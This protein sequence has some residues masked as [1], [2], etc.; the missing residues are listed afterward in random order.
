MPAA[1]ALPGRR[2]V[3]PSAYFGSRTPHRPGG[4]FFAIVL[5]CKSLLSLIPLPS[6]FSPRKA[7]SEGSSPPPPAP[8]SHASQVLPPTNMLYF[9]LHCGA[10]FSEYM[11]ERSDST[12]THNPWNLRQHFLFF[13]SLLFS[14]PQKQPSSKGATVQTSDS[15]R[16]RK[17]KTPRTRK[18]RCRNLHRHAWGAR[19][20]AGSLERL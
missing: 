6:L 1:Q 12:K 10:R 20:A 17:R 14:S 16:P 13:L 7:R 3:P 5:Q 4:A 18:T 9:E 2:G 8:S 11:N 15:L 19:Q